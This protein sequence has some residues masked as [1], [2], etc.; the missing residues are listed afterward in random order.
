MNRY[1]DL[2][3]DT[4]DLHCHIDLEFS[5][6]LFRKR[7][8][9]DE[10]LPAAERSGVRGVVLKSHLWPTVSVVPFIRRLYGGP[11]EVWPSITL[12]PAAGGVDLWSVEAAY[13]Q[14]ARV[15]FLPTWGSANDL[16]NGGFHRRLADRFEWFRPDRLCVQRVTGEDG[17]P[18]DEVRD[19]VRFC[20]EHGLTL[21]TGHVSW[22]ESLAVAEE[23]SAIGFDRLICS[24]P[25]SNSVRA[26]LDAVRRIT[27]L[28]AYAEVCWTNIAPGRLDPVDVVASMREVGL[29]RVVVATDYFVG[30]S[31]PPPD[32]LRLTLGTLHDAGLTEAEIRRVAAENPARVLGL[33]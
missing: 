9:E 7:G 13:H 11:V 22:Q 17:K 6:T 28:G 5:E 32:L 4:I 30:A 18:T 19:L 26:P 8:P 29:G 16:R 15:V 2:L 24:H 1:D 27:E 25:F 31:P 10:W 21:A 12:N 23:A 3:R 33:G 14:G 20:H